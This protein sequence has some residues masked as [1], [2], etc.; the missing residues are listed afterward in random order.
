[1][2]GETDDI[3]L[4]ASVDPLSSCQGLVSEGMGKGHMH[5]DFFT[6][7]PRVKAHKRTRH[8][9]RHK[10][11]WFSLAGPHWA[12]CGPAAEFQHQ[13]RCEAGNM[14]P[15]S[16]VGGLKSN[17]RLERDANSEAAT[18]DLLLKIFISGVGGCVICHLWPF[19]ERN[20]QG[21]FFFFYNL[22]VYD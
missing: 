4:K 5:V 15:I 11:L 21:C 8:W 1:M 2:S 18:P 13:S 3:L 20:A 17:H 19:I 6:T 9:R 10:D 12:L 22:K 16:D 7:C 14:T